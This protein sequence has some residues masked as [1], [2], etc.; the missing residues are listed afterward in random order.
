MLFSLVLHV[1]SNNSK[2]GAIVQN[3]M[4]VIK[5]IPVFIELLK[6]IEAAIP[7]QGQGTAKLQAVRQILEL[8]DSSIKEAWPMVQGVIE[9]LVK[10]FNTTG[11]FKK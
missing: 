2:Q 1:D 9:V 3:L 6:A 10:T 11:V 5:L 7:E 8:T 4:L